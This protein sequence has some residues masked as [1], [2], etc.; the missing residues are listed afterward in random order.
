MI[1]NLYPQFKF[2]CWDKKDKQIKD[3]VAL[4]FEQSCI[5]TRHKDSISSGTYFNSFKNKIEDR[6]MIMSS[7]GITYRD[8]LL[9]NCDIMSFKD[10]LRLN[11]RWHGNI[12]TCVFVNGADVFI[13]RDNISSYS[14]IVINDELNRGI[15]LP[16]IALDNDNKC[17]ITNLYNYK[18]FKDMNYSKRQDKYKLLCLTDAEIHELEENIPVNI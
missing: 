4:D 13:K 9:Y 8:T 5:R 15:Y 1:E 7:I 2:K 14:L 11:F 6:H 12:E 16:T 3:V 18:G 10:E 17:E